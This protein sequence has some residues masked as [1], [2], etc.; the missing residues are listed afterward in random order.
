MKKKSCLICLNNINKIFNFNF[1]HNNSTSN[2]SNYNYNNKT[3]LLC[4]NKYFQKVKQITKI[5]YK[6]FKY[7]NN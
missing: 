2:N 3:N 5:F 4:N 6:G 7:F 1:K